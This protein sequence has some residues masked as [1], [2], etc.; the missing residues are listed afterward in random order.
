MRTSLI[1]AWSKTTVLSFEDAE[2]GPLSCPW[3]G[4]KVL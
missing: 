4:V 3:M 1:P 2:N